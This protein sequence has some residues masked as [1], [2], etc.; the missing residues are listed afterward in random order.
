MTGSLVVLLQIWRALSH[1]HLSGCTL[2][3]VRV[4]GTVSICVGG[5]AVD[6]CGQSFWAPSDLYIKGI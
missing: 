6:R 4:K 3:M 1:M 5:F 2:V